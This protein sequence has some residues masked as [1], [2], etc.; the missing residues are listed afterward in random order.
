[1]TYSDSSDFFIAWNHTVVTSLPI[2]EEHFLISFSEPKDLKRQIS[3]VSKCGL[4]R[5]GNLTFDFL[6]GGCSN[7]QDEAILFCFGDDK[8]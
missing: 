7:W 8:R 6:Y 3:K 1:M 4:D 2:F 5:V